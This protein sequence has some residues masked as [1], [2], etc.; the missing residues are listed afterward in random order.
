MILL[1]T[2]AWILTRTEPGFESFKDSLWYCFATV[3]TIGYGEFTATTDLG[4]IISV[5]LGMYGIVAVALITSIIVNFYNEVRKHHPEEDEPE[6]N[7][8]E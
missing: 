3:T 1:L 2:F 8:G 6:M 5:I 4:R 7:T